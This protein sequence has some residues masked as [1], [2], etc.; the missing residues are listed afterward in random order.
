ME[1]YKERNRENEYRDQLSNDRVDLS[2]EPKAINESVHLD[3]C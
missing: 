3:E 2:L 1:V